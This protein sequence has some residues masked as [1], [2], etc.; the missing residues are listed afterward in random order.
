MDIQKIS[1]Q[2]MS[3]NARRFKPSRLS[4]ALGLA[5]AVVSGVG[6]AATS[7]PDYPLQTNVG[8]I[9]PNI[10]F[11][12]DNS[13]SMNDLAM[14]DGL[15]HAADF[16][17]GGRRYA[18]N[19]DDERIYLSG[20]NLIAYDP[21]K[22]YEPW[23]NY[24]GSRKTL[25]TTPKAVLPNPNHSVEG[26]TGQEYTIDLTR[27]DTSHQNQYR[28]RIRKYTTDFLV[29]R[30]HGLNVSRYGSYYRY[31]YD[32]ARKTWRRAE[33]IGGSND[34]STGYQWINSA[35]LWGEENG[36][37]AS[38]VWGN[39]V[40]VATPLGV[41][42]AV[43]DHG[44]DQ[45]TNYVIWYSYHRFRMSVAK[46]GASEAFYRLGED[47]RV[48]FDLIAQ[49]GTPRWYWPGITSTVNDYTG[50]VMLP[51]PV[52]QDSGLFR[53]SNKQNWFRYLHHAPA[54]QWTPLRQA[55]YRT[56]NYY[57]TDDSVW[58]TNGSGAKYSCRRSYAILTTDGYWNGPGGSSVFDAAYAVG[59]ADGT[60]SANY[61]AARPFMDGK[62]DTL[63]DIA[64]HFWKT[65][66]R[67]DLVND[68]SASIKNP[69]TW[70]HMVT[71]GVSIGLKGNMEPNDVTLAELR[72]G[73][74]Q[75]TDPIAN[76]GGARI[77]DLWHAAV[78]S[79]GSFVVASDADAFAQALQDAL[80]AIA[81]ENGSGGGLG[82]TGRKVGGG[83]RIYQ[84]HYQSGTWEGDVQAFDF[85]SGNTDSAPRLWSLAENSL[86]PDLFGSGQGFSSRPVFTWNQAGGG[87]AVLSLAALGSKASL[88]ARTSGSAAVSA[89]DNLK[90][91]KGDRSLEKSSGGNLRDRQ[92]SLIGDVVNSVPHYVK[93]SDTLFVG[94][95]DGML[96]AVNAAD[97][98]PLFS[99]M[100]RGIDYQAL[101]ELS[102]PRYQHRFFV[103]GELRVSNRAT[104]SGK[105]ILI[106]S[107]GR[108]GKGLFAL[109]VT[110]PAG[111]TAANVL[112]DEDSTVNADLG[113]ILS[114]PLIVPGNNG[115]ALVI[116][117]NGLESQGGNAKLLVYEL[118]AA[119][120]VAAR[121]AFGQTSGSG[122][123]MT[124]FTAYDRNADGKV[125]F[126]YAGD[127][128]GNVWKIDLSGSSAASWG[129][130]NGGSPMFTARDPSGAAQPITGGLVVTVE[131]K[132][133]R[134]FISFGTGKYLS[135]Q[136][137]DVSGVQQTQTLYALID[138][139]APITGR[140]QL[141]RRTFPH[142]GTTAD[143]KA[144]RAAEDYSE[145]PSGVRGW[146]LDLGVPVALNRGERIVT[147]PEVS[148]E[149]LA[150]ASLV[151]GA[152]QGCSPGLGG[153][154]TAL[155]VFTGTN[156]KEGGYFDFNGDGVPD[157]MPG[158]GQSH[159]SSVDLG[160]GTGGV[161]L[162]RNEDG[163]LSAVT[164]GLDGSRV[165]TRLL[166]G[167][168]RGE[169]VNW[170]ELVNT[171]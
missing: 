33:W 160:R 128:Q 38:T 94:A 68:V 104:T 102:D 113:Y 93:E 77:D 36:P 114:Q 46:A 167:G 144:V 29:L 43:P 158:G 53:A 170:R 7:F 103:D 79:R 44:Q 83:S 73:T 60:N 84:G 124:D 107:L 153:Y 109:D 154:L 87:G 31:R 57:H 8:T 136:D 5:V 56:G 49:S 106:S 120:Q 90:Y 152:S 133:G 141:H 70:Q 139:N 165:T 137:K 91:L 132:T 81:A 13:G 85:S 123:G 149:I 47:Y 40:D 108:G 135:E 28:D 61:T 168:S 16:T 64:M 151:P 76:G 74:R 25:G 67:D 140:S 115:R 1:K 98:K 66:L 134:V 169:R 22:K 27:Q 48:G 145:L 12:L 97:G 26:A 45:L 34:W 59:N 72:S 15:H 99:Y 4:F 20:L 39:W 6:N 127:I 129:V 148:G 19:A 62:S 17:Y 100:P 9:P 23:R 24:D 162:Y 69:A 10:M 58:T 50:K 143:G 122:N 112:W 155:N 86:N 11:I 2:Q 161:R 37:Y 3:R 118:N 121:H 111:F 95:N 116:T 52:S 119:G 147:R 157:Q 163:S 125:D 75:W 101:A 55:L 164:P 156:P 41:G 110:N 63:A 117:A 89:A 65:D 166:G 14:P 80:D 21:M 142:H 51:I 159:V 92:S 88:L 71:F 54:W 150:V 35:M 105:N 82:D 131:R 130:S 138:G 30:N 171:H 126:V 96:H 78:N 42:G 146:Y 32:F 18:A